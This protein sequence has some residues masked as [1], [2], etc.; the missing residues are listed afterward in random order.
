MLEAGLTLTAEY[1]EK[2]NSMAHPWGSCPAN[3]IVEHLFGLKPTSPGWKTY[4]YKVSPLLQNAEL[5]LK[6]PSGII[7]IKG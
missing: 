1:W 4:E 2:N 7:H 6:T 5:K 3:I